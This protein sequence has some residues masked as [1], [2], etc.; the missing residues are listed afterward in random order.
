MLALDE[1]LLSMLVTAEEVSDQMLLMLLVEMKF[2]FVEKMLILQTVADGVALYYG[3]LVANL[4]LHAYIQCTESIVL[5]VL[6]DSL[7]V[8]IFI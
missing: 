5:S 8:S 4:R 2:Y 3:M 7:T 1:V 6:L